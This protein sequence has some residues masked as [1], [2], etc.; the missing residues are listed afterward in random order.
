LQ[1]GPPGTVAT[2]QESVGVAPAAQQRPH[3]PDHLWILD[4]QRAAH[5]ALGRIVE[6][7][8]LLVHCH[9]LAQQRGDAVRVVLLG[10]LLA[11]RAEVAEIE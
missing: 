7:D 11:A 3:G 8:G 4:L 5:P 9:V 10:V 2:H 1:V 6:L